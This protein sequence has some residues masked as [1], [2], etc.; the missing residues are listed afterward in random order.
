MANFSVRV[1]LHDAD[2]AE[3]DALHAAMDKVGFKTT[4]IFEGKTYQ[5][6]PAE[7]TYTSGTEDTR[8]VLN[9]AVAVAKSVKKD[10]AVGVTKSDGG[11]LY[12]G[13]KLVG[14]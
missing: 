1:E 5:L 14:A 11:R 2:S 6:P 9:K 12:S 13:L 10:P 8:A 4:V 7:Y 3:Y